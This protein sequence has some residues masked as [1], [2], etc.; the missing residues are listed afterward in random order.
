[1]INNCVVVLRLFFLT[2]ILPGIF[3]AQSVLAIKL[4]KYQFKGNNIYAINFDPMK[5]EMQIARALDGQIGRENI[6]SIAKRNSALA[7]INGS[8]WESGGNVNGIPAFLLKVRDQIF[9][10]KHVYPIVYFGKT[11]RVEFTKISTDPQIIIGNK[12]FSCAINMPAIKAPVTL[13]TTA[14]A[15]ST[16]SYPGVVEVIIEDNK[17]IK[18]S[19]KGN[20][21]IAG[22]GFVLAANDS[23]TAK[24]LK[25]LKVGTDIELG[26]TLPSKIGEAEYIISGSNML[27]TDG[28]LDEYLTDEHNAGSF[29]DMK[30]ARSAICKMKNGII[31]FIATDY[32]YEEDIKTMNVGELWAYF[33]KHGMGMEEV[34]QMTGKEIV[35]TYHKLS[36][37]HNLSKGL[38][39]HDFAHALKDYGCVDA[40]NLDGGSSTTL[41]YK[42]KVITGKRPQLMEDADAI[43]VRE[44]K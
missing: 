23:K 15:A 24:F 1:M 32:V 28:E 35:S 16:L 2:F 12:K 41:V 10:A 36:A 25:S 33:K 29:R 42:D 30:H 39:M 7:A 27:L 9:M 6:L 18:V 4:D 20:N 34:M 13:Y 8:F 37:E 26:D 11:G 5:Y 3:S 19:S 38:N 43:I 21:V 17:V 40:L 44:K 31:A 22:N 14:Y